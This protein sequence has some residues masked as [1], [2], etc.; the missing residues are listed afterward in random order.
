M[1]F[2]EEFKG[3]GPYFHFNMLDVVHD[4]A[5]LVAGIDC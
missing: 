2:S 5:I 3:V 1:S 4:I